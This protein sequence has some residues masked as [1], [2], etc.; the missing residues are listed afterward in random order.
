MREIWALRDQP[1]RVYMQNGRKLAAALA[2]AW[3][4]APGLLI[5][6]ALNAILML[7]ECCPPRAWWRVFNEPNLKMHNEPTVCEV[8]YPVLGI[9]RAQNDMV[10]GVLE[11][12]T[13]AATP[14][15]QGSATQ[16]TVKGLPDP[17][18]AFVTVNDQE[19]TRWH[20]SASDAIRIEVDVDEHYLRIAFQTPG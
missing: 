4:V 3:S 2:N 6:I 20:V 14:S 11:I 1:C 9:R 10:R 19:F 12:E 15:R 16:F 8:D 5:I 7:S 18:N 17:A 13:I